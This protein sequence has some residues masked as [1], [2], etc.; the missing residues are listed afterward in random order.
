MNTRLTL[1]HIARYLPWGLKN[2]VTSDRG[3]YYDYPYHR[4]KGFIFDFN[5]SDTP[6]RIFIY[7]D[8]QTW[9]DVVF[10]R[11][12]PILR[13]C[14]LTKPIIHNREEII[15]IVHLFEKCLVD[16]YKHVP[17]YK[18]TLVDNSEHTSGLVAHI[19]DYRYGFTF[20]CDIDDNYV[21]FELS[22][23][24]KDFKST[25]LKINQEDLFQKLYEWKFD[26]QGLIEA[27]LAVDVETLSTNPYS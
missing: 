17:E 13:R 25:S 18:L 8:N 21:E 19:D 23:A 16:I 27:G 7:K 24:Y 11:S 14:D 2:I 3:M 10:E 15:P 5:I 1:E 6:K 12:K 20:N 26:T 9:F 22:N 4:D